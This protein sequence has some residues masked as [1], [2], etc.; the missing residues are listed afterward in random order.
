MGWEWWNSEKINWFLSFWVYGV[1]EMLV[2]TIRNGIFKSI[3]M[4]F[5]ATKSGT[6]KIHTEI[7]IS[8]LL[9]QNIKDGDEMSAWKPLTH[10]GM[11]KSYGW[12]VHFCCLG[13]LKIENWCDWLGEA[14]KDS[15]PL[16][17]LCWFQIL[18]LKFSILCWQC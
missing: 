12:K 16:N 1:K 4:R 10:H 17:F 13:M 8:N 14:T 3:F 6:K 11:T 9:L 18:H 2:F 7:I 15:I 5:L